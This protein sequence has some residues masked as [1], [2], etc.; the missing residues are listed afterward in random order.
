MTIRMAALLLLLGPLSL[1]AET[2]QSSLGFSIDIP[3]N[4]QL[5]TPGV[6]SENRK[7]QMLIALT[8]GRANAVIED[9]ESGKVEYL[10]L[11]AGAE[12]E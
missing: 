6:V 8:E 3:D 4:W 9:I 12:G 10:Y 1:N 11:D 7:S 5:V 2:M